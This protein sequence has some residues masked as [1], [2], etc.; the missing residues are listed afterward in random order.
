MSK[1]LRGGLIEGQCCVPDAP[2]QFG[3]MCTERL[4]QCYDILGV[5][6]EFGVE[7]YF[8]VTCLVY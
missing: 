8:G 6:D 2:D 3:P 1:T 5:P 7:T 4:C